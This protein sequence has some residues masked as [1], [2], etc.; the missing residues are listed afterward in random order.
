MDSFM[1]ERCFGRVGL[2]SV[3]ETVETPSVEIHVLADTGGGI[4]FQQK[5]EQIETKEDEKND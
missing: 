1:M 2:E 5:T 3:G 4:R